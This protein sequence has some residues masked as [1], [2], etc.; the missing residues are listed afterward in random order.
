M[1]HAARLLGTWTLLS[2]KRIAA[3]GTVTWPHTEQ[4][5]G[6]L[7]Y[8]DRGLMAGFLMAPAHAQGERSDGS[9]LFVGYSGRFE[10]IGDIANHHVD[11]AADV[12]M[13]H[14]VLRRRIEWLWADEVR[15]HTLAPAGAAERESSHQLT[16]KRDPAPA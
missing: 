2:W 8:S 15:L 6:R 9:P 11:F 16:W 10:V 5:T 12:R 7:I 13:L 4:G 3:D 1:D 14:K